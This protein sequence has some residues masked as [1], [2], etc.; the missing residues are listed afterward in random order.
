MEELFQIVLI[1]IFLLAGLLG[2]RKKK[3]SEK[4][5]Q[6]RPSRPRRPPV[7]RPA[8]PPT[9]ATAPPRPTKTPQETLLDLLMKQLPEEMR[10][11]APEPPPP[12]LPPEPEEAVSLEPL[13]IDA[14]ARH[15]A[16]HE[17]YPESSPAMITPSRPKHRFLRSPTSLRD[18]VIWRAVLGPPK[19]LE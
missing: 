10:A 13:D 6:T 8:R 17:R 15:E 11:P 9:A 3:P 16:F 2:S 18:A 14:A 19:G 1:A 12:P 7:A 4:R 5:P